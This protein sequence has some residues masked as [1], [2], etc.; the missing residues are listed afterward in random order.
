MEATI[1]RVKRT[2]DFL[3]HQPR[4]GV[5]KTPPEPEFFFTSEEFLLLIQNAEASSSNLK[6]IESKFEEA[7]KN[8]DKRTYEDQKRIRLKY[9][10]THGL[11]LKNIP[12][13]FS[14]T[15]AYRAI[16]NL[17]DE[18][19]QSDGEKVH[20]P[21]ELGMM[22][23]M[24]PKI[25][26][27]KKFSEGQ[28]AFPIFKNRSDRDMLWRCAVLNAS[29]SDK[30]VNKENDDRKGLLYLC[31]PNT[32]KYSLVN[33]ELVRNEIGEPMNDVIEQDEAKLKNK[34]A[35][36]EKFKKMDFTTSTASKS[37]SLAGSRRSSISVDSFTAN[38]LINNDNTNFG[39]VGADRQTLPNVIVPDDPY[40]DPY[41]QDT[42]SDYHPIS[43]APSLS[44]LN[45]D[46]S[47]SS[48][49]D[50]F[51]NQVTNVTDG[52]SLATALT[53]LAGNVHVMMSESNKPEQGVRYFQR[54][55][56]SIQR[57]NVVVKN[58]CG[59][60]NN[61]ILFE[62][63]VASSDVSLDLENLNLSEKKQEK[64]EV[65][66]RNVAEY[67]KWA[68]NNEEEEVQVEGAVRTTDIRAGLVNFNK[69]ESTQTVVAQDD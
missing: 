50:Q 25:K 39:H 47:V 8:T 53:D 19:Q 43:K 27:R 2:L 4:R 36:S 59:E 49:V 11:C 24:F 34:N 65:K 26:D 3:K 23:F 28:T 22:Q 40:S 5:K 18:F 37:S 61:E 52:N 62:M 69:Q 6:L 9:Q 54:R 45:S 64:Q 29:K 35:I 68:F 67:Q 20:F 12:F 46:I 13:E 60:N 58:D 30:N 55:V 41:L 33:V 66:K 44:S 51:G 48:H 7:E 16:Q 15:D 17:K 21:G 56:S 63:P 32:E 38:P 57:G 10:P 42:L 1:D 31:H 14:R